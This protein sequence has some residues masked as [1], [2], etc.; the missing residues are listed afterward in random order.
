[1]LGNI[2]MK[3][4]PDLSIEYYQKIIEIDAGYHRAYYGL[5]TLY[6]SPS[7]CQLSATEQYCYGAPSQIGEFHRPLLVY[8]SISCMQ[9]G[10]LILLSLK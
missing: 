6:L 1:M 7:S 4:N 5:G 2:N 10:S 3:K 8:V 9:Q